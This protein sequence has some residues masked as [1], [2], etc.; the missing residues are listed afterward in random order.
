MADPQLP[1]GATA[2]HGEKMIEIRVRF[3]TEKIAKGE[4]ILPKHCWDC[5]EVVVTRNAS[6]DITPKKS[7]KFN[8]IFELNK[9]IETVLAEN[10]IKLHIGSKLSK[11]L[12]Q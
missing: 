11:I 1:L 10:E 4:N 7:V 8:S 12:S 9:K 5:G 6:H 2:K 3:W